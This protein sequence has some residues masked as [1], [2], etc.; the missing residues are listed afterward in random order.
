MTRN[1]TVSGHGV[2]VASESDPWQ[3][4][5]KNVSEVH[6]ARGGRRAMGRR[7]KART[8]LPRIAA[9]A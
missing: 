8:T 9:T 6:V 2:L 3:D 1:R 4:L 7:S 5:R